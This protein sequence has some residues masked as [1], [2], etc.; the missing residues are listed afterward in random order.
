[1]NIPPTAEMLEGEDEEFMNSVYQPV[2]KAGDV[3][4]FSE[5]TIHGCLPWTADRQRRIA[6][7]RFAP[8][9]FA[10]S[11]QYSEGWPKSYTDEMTPE[12]LAVMKA[13]YSTRYDRQILNDDGALGQ[14]SG[15]SQ[16]KK[17]FDDEVFGTKYH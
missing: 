12:Q 7:Y 2:G 8:G 5:A 10:Y 13:P 1:M 4:I 11:R 6:L 9:N 14:P 15:R 17:E 16:R 3:V